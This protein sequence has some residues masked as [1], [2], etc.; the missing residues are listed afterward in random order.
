[1]T[2]LDSWDGRPTEEA[3]LFNPAFIGSLVYE[4]VKSFQKSRPDGVPLTFVP[5]AL[6]I[7]LHRPTRARL[8]GSTVTSL[9]EWVQNNEDVLVG[10]H[11]RVVGLLPYIR[12]GIQFS[13]Y[14][15]SIWLGNGHYIQLGE[16]RAHF[17]SKFTRETSLDVSDAIKRTQ[18]IGRWFVKSGSEASILACWGVRP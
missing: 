12:E 2:T 9:Y 13:M 1:V 11:D 7:S 4:F 6:A 8:P 18:F 3:N 17:N 15:N 16:V 14:K 5:I 10:F